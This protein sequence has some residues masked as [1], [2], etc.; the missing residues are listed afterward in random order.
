LSEPR[1][2]IGIAYDRPSREIIVTV[3]I[4]SSPWFDGSGP[5]LEAALIETLVATASYAFELETT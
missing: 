4:N 5:T 3:D 2:D 1:I